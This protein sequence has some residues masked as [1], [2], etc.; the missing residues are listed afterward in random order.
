MSDF[1]KIFLPANLYKLLKTKSLGNL[2]T[3]AGQS[4]EAIDVVEWI[5]QAIQ[6]GYINTLISGSGNTNLSHSRNASTVTIES[7]SGTDTV[8]TSATSTNAGILTAGDKVIYDAAAVK[9]TDLVVLSGVPKNN[10]NLG[11]FTGDTIPDDV[12]IK[13]ALQALET[14]IDAGL[15]SENGISGTG[16]ST[17]K[18]KLGGSLNQDTNID[19]GG[20]R[21]YTES[22]LLR[23]TIT[24]DTGV[25]TS[26]AKTYLDL[27]SLLT[28]G[29]RLRSEVRGNVNKYAEVR[30]DPDGTLTAIEQKDGSDYSGAYMSGAGSVE[31]KSVVGG[32]TKTM[33]VNSAGHY[34]EN[35]P[36]GT[37]TQI[38]Y[39]DSATGA[40]TR[41]TTPSGG[42][43]VTDGDKGDIVVS[44]GGATWLLE[45]IFTPNTYGAANT[46]PVI[47]I[48][49][50]GRIASA[51]NTTINITA[52]QVN[53]FDEASQD[54]VGGMADPTLV[55]NDTTPSLGRAAITGDVSVPSGSNTSTIANNAVNDAKL[56][57]MA[58]N[59]VKCRA[60]S[61]SGDPGNLAIAN[62][63]LF[64]RGAS[65]DLS[66]ISLG[67]NLSMSGTTLNAT[68]GGGSSIPES[69]FQNGCLFIASAVGCTFTR[70]TA[71]IWTINV[72]AGVELYSADIYSQQ[73]D[74][75]GANVTLNIN[76]A[77]AV[78]NSSV[79]T[80]RM[81]LISG[82]NLGSGSGAVPANYAPTTG[83]TNLQTSVNSVG[84]GDIQLLINNFNN[85]SGLGTGATILKVKW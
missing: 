36:I 29:G 50:K 12:T 46:V 60:A 71:S 59:T 52:A 53:N 6:E 31:L 15:Q 74:N 21:N 20:N 43:G 55:Y 14:S 62:N 76:T 27:T 77:S 40:I 75:P 66:P 11:I 67:T 61:T 9:A 16:K 18:F 13:A 26:T 22:N 72:P 63:Q 28:G 48:D 10:I 57:D 70:D 44:G 64:G 38:L 49:A 68:G 30:V 8:L 39:I 47:S 25:D 4:N 51:T 1:K 2:Q 84:S 41:G 23:R 35:V 34:M 79:L 33:G 80:I 85:A 83:A 45:S 19:G 42:G 7:D 37:N 56:A 81:P 5:N 54:A 65:G 69:Y 17:S 73:S 78:Y 32:S 58:A 3:Q 82:I 24:V